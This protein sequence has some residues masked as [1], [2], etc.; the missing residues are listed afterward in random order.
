MLPVDGNIV[1]WAVQVRVPLRRQ[2]I[3]RRHARQPL[4]CCQVLLERYAA[5][6]LVAAR[7]QSKGGGAAK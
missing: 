2:H 3:L 5:G 7:P 1:C 4:Q 6:G